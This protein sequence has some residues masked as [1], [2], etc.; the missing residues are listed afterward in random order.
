MPAP[1]IT[2]LQQQG[3]KPNTFPMTGQDATL[4]GL[5]NIISGYQCGTVYKPIFLEAQ[6]ATALAMYLRA[7]VK[8]PAALINGTTRGHASPTCRFRR[9]S[10]P[11]V[12]HGDDDRDDGRQGQVR[13]RIADLLARRRV[14]RRGLREV[15]DQEM[16]KPRSIGSG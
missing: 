13:P 6:A 15:Q 2:Y 9:C 11:R 4:V 10:R 5:Q 12:G 7:G 1:I 8:P 3:V 14:L 16:T